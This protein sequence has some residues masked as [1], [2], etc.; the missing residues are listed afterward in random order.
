MDH[1]FDIYYKGSLCRLV[2]ASKTPQFLIEQNWVLGF[3]FYAFPYDMIPIPKNMTRFITYY[4]SKFP[5]DTYAVYP[6][7]NPLDEFYELDTEPLNLTTTFIAY[8]DGV[9]NTVPLHVFE[10]SVGE[11]SSVFITPSQYP[12]VDPVFASGYKESIFSPFYVPL[13]PIDEFK[14]VNTICIPA[15]PTSY[16]MLAFPGWEN[17]KNDKEAL[18]R[19]TSAFS[20]KILGAHVPKD[21]RPS[22]SIYECLRACKLPNERSYT[23]PMPQPDPVIY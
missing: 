12:P 9:E 13:R 14:C 15:Q 1:R 7:Y 2:Q 8:S 23:Y 3:S 20:D 16:K 6:D 22:Y 21:I 18:E 10:R 5:Y 4:R 17:L 11:Y 19:V